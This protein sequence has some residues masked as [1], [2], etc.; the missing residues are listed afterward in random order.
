ME[1]TDKR[2]FVLVT[3]LIFLSIAW[4]AQFSQGQQNLTYNDSLVQMLD[5]V[6]AESAG[7][8]NIRSDSVNWYEANARLP[9]RN[10]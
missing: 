7:L 3:T 1:K 2:L 5:A 10:I 8:M 4:F 6:R 9:S